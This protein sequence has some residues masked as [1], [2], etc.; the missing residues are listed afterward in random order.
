MTAIFELIM[1]RSILADIPS[2]LKEMAH[3]NNFTAAQ[4]TGDKHT[5]KLTANKILI[6]FGIFEP[7]IVL[8]KCYSVN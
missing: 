2:L 6:W 7:E 4:N 5:T 3:T 8:K 1:P